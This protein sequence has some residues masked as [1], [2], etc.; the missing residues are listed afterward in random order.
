M[1]YT[2]KQLQILDVAAELFADNG[3][4]G[5]SVRDIAKAADVNIAMISYY[6]GSKEKLLEAIFTKHSAHIKL[7]LENIIADKN[8]EPFEKMELMVDAYLEKYFKQQ[9]I[10]KIVAR[11]Q[12]SNQPTPLTPLLKDMKKRNHELVKKLIQEGQ[13]KGVF[14]KT[15][16]IQLLMSTMMGT[17]NLFVN[18]Q[19]FYREMNNLE[20]LSE[21]EFQKLIK[22]KLTTHLKSIFKAILT[23]ED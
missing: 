10:H 19:S 13:K 14:K 7:Q 16:D 20:H 1:E 9:C 6:F 22:K 8:K 15:V 11:S 2:E 12:I 21:D 3:F 5:T 23:N 18:S 17:A 4:D